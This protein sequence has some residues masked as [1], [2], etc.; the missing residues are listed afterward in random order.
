MDGYPLNLDW[1]LEP[2]T[3]GYAA[4]LSPYARHSNGLHVWAERSMD[5]YT[6]C[7]QMWRGWRCWVIQSL[8]LWFHYRGD[9]TK[10]DLNPPGKLT[11]CGR[12]CQ[13]RK[14]G[15][16]QGIVIYVPTTPSGRH[17]NRVAEIDNFFRW[18]SPGFGHLAKTIRQFWQTRT[19]NLVR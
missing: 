12:T 16:W 3:R 19:G 11:V 6:Y 9:M 17:E 5:Y 2:R 8:W 15:C 7:S 18:G 14:R 4:A 1:R 13:T 10:G